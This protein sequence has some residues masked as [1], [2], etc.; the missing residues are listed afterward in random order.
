MI[1]LLICCIHKEA[2]I[3]IVVD[4]SIIKKKGDNMYS[5]RRKIKPKEGH[6][7]LLVWERS[8]GGWRQ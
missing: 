5:K 2:L 8:V 6:V 3:I 4:I 1:S 7:H